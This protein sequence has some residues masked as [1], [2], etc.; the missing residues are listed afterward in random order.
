M[1]ETGTIVYSIQWLPYSLN[2]DM[3]DAPWCSMT[4]T[5]ASRKHVDS[6]PADLRDLFLPPAARAEAFVPGRPVKGRNEPIA[7]GA[8]AWV[9][10]KVKEEAAS[11][12]EEFVEQGWRNTIELFQLRELDT[13]SHNALGSH[14]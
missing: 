4:S 10:H 3:K 12:F 6:L 2:D 5:H 8:V 1:F 11:G 14:G 9:A 13:N 7:I